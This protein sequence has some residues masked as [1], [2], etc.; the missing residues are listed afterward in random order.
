MENIEKNLLYRFDSDT[1]G[2]SYEEMD[3]IS[4]NV[5]RELMCSIENVAYFDAESSKAAF[6]LLRI[7]VGIAVLE[8]AELEVYRNGNIKLTSDKFCFSD[9]G[10]AL[11]EQ[12]CSLIKEIKIETATKKC[13]VLI[14]I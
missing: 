7:C 3:V 13:S 10:V 4:D 5:F 8:C 14:R 9:N 1:H 12:M 6:R 2:K 11:F